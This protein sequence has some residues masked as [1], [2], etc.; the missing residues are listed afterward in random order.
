MTTKWSLFIIRNAILFFMNEPTAFAQSLTHT[1][2]GATILG[3]VVIVL[4]FLFLIYTSVTKKQSG[5]LSFFAKNVIPL[6]FLISLFGTFLTLYYSEVL[7]YV[8]CDLCWFQRIFLYPQLFIFALAWYKNDR[9]ILP[10]TTVLSVFGFLIAW[11][12]HLLQIGYDIYKPCSTAPFAVD[13]AKPSFIE[14]GFVT[15][16]FMAV[17]LFGTLL[18]LSFT[19]HTFAK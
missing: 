18:V 8:P 13:C 3:G 15:F 1:L 12:H 16:P 4:W 9:K 10:Y 6:G 17:V 5:I 14:Y 11:Y 7:H 2:A 19:A